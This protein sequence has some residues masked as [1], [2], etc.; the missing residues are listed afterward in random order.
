MPTRP[1]EMNPEL[2]KETQP[3]S[4]GE[5]VTDTVGRVVSRCFFSIFG[6]PE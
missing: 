5:R 3:H 1:S 6:L 2:P 4:I